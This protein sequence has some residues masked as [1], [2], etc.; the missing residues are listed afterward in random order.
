M[1]LDLKIMPA[2]SVGAQ[3]SLDILS[4]DRDNM[5]FTLIKNIEL[6]FGCFADKEFTSLLN[7]KT[8]YNQKIK[9]L[10]AKRL[11]NI[12][13]QY[14]FDSKKNKAILQYIKNLPSDLEIYLYWC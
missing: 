12:P 3:F 2:Y 11:K 7:K 5:L 10:K 1:G 14:Y 6:R 9:Y 8:P 13:K 4:F